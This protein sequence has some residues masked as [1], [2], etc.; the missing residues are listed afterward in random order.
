MSQRTNVS[1]LPEL[2]QVGQSALTSIGDISSLD[3]SKINAIVQEATDFDS[4]QDM[5]GTAV[6]EYAAKK[7]QPIIK[8]INRPVLQKYLIV[9]DF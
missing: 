5:F 1:S 6:K 4:W 3:E 8:F 9:L 2:L 7:I